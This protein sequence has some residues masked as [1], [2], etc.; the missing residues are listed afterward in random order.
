[1]AHWIEGI[2]VVKQTSDSRTTIWD[3]AKRAGVSHS[4]V[5]LAM[6]G[7]PGVSE[8]RAEQIRKIAQQ[9]NYQPRMAAQMMRA[10]KIRQLG[11]IVPGNDVE[12]TAYSGH[13]APIMM[14]F[15]NQCDKR[16]LRYHIEFATTLPDDQFTLPVQLAGRMVDGALLA[17]FGNDPLLDWLQNQKEYP[18][19][20]L[21]E[22]ADYCVLSQMDQGLYDAM[23]YLAALG[24]RRVAHFGGPDI[25]LNHQLS[26][27]GFEKAIC[28]FGMTEAKVKQPPY[29]QIGKTRDWVEVSM[30][31]AHDVLSEKRRPTAIVCQGAI[32]VQSVYR[33]AMQKG[34]SVPIDVSVIGVGPAAFAESMY[35]F[36]TAIEQ[37]FKWL[38]EKALDV[39]QRQID[40]RQAVEPQTHWVRPNLVIRDSTCRVTD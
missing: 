20:R 15:V 33:V 29:N 9:M 19:V 8:K 31:W 36:M 2:G 39:L 21:D 37:D 17:G 11:L 7:A 28:D 14:H 18:W 3:V 1:L 16:D 25:Y 34:L 30:Q 23:Q 32:P 13:G 27:Q 26:R 24:H 40:G 5:S 38:V 6:R 35:P 12:T 22:K 4:A 10:K